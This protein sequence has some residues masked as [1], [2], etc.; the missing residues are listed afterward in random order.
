MI[1]DNNRVYEGEWVNNQRH[2]KGYEKFA[3]GNKFEGLY[4]NNK[5]HG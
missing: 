4:Q 2:G 5:A 3:N 1:Y